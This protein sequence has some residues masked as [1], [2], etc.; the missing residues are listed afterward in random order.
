MSQTV[1]ELLDAAMALSEDERSELAELI[2][3]SLPP[4][5]RGLHPD[6]PAELRRRYDEVKSGAVKAIPW[7]EVRRRLNAKYGLDDTTHG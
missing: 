1:A 2:E 4:V 7:E 6:W 5:P 3:A